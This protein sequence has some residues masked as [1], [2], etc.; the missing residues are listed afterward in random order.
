[1]PMC[2]RRNLR[3][4]AL[5][6]DPIQAQ[7]AA[8]VVVE[9]GQQVDQGGLAGAG[10]SEQGDHLTRL[11]GERNLVQHRS[12]FGIFETDRLEFD[13]AFK[14]RRG[15]DIAFVQRL[16]LL[17]DDL[18]HPVV[19]DQ[20]GGSLHDQAPHVAQRPDQPDDQ[21]GISQVGA[22]RDGAVDRQHGAVEVAEQELRAAGDIRDRPEQGMHHQQA[23]AAQVLFPVIFFELACA[24]N[25]GGQ[26]P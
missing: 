4:I 16:L 12:V 2:W 8:G 25:P 26:T 22:H 1:M 7:A 9:A 15:L 10:R 19:R 18:H 5:Q 17:A 21:P 23:L 6:L 24:R 20:T 11:A 14:T 3:G 13:L